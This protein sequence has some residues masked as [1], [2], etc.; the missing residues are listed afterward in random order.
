[1][2]SPELA[3]AAF[4]GDPDN[5]NFPRWCLDMSFLRVYEDGKPASTPNYL[6]WRTEGL[7]PSPEADLHYPRGIY[8]YARGIAYARTG[9]LD[10]AKEELARLLGY[11]GDRTLED[12]KIWE[13]NSTFHLL[14]IA[15]DVLRGEIEAGKGNWDL[16]IE[17]LEDAVSTEDELSY[18][19][20]P[21]WFFPARHILGA[22]LL[23]ATLDYSETARGLV[24]P[25][26]RYVEAA[27]ALLEVL[28]LPERLAT[29]R[30][31]APRAR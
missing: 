16:A 19:E 22:I 31:D 20:P 27:D 14:Q 5:F 10:Q 25:D 9:R 11:A 4:G 28:A 7:E 30:G 18:N 15:L 3:I 29:W 17:Y 26:R 8:H 12:Q 2:F 24:T 1:M 23:E 6:Q 21:D 13:I